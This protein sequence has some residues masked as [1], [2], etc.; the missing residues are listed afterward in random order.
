MKV[1]KNCDGFQL[2]D[3]QDRG[4]E[5]VRTQCAIFLGI[6]RI[7][8]F[9]REKMGFQCWLSFLA[10]HE[11]Q[12]KGIMLTHSRNIL[13][14]EGL[15]AAKVASERLCRESLAMLMDGA[16]DDSLEEALQSNPNMNAEDLLSTAALESS[17]MWTKI[18]ELRTGEERVRLLAEASAAAAAVP[19]APSPDPAPVPVEVDGQSGGPSL[20]DARVVEEEATEVQKTS[21]TKFF[22][23]LIIPESMAETLSGKDEAAELE[24]IGVQST[25]TFAEMPR[26][27]LQHFLQRHPLL[28][29]RTEDDRILYVYDCKAQNDKFSERY[30][31]RPFFLLPPLDESHLATCLAATGPQDKDMFVILD[32]R[33]LEAGS[34][35]KKA[36]NKSS[37]WKGAASF[38]FRLC[39]DNQEFGVGGYAST[40]TRSSIGALPEPIET[41]MVMHGKTVELECRD[42]RYLNLPGN[43][44]TRAL[45]GIHLR[46]SEEHNLRIPSSVMTMVQEGQSMQSDAAAVDKGAAAGPDTAS[47]SDED[48]LV[49]FPWTCEENVYLEFLNFWAHDRAVVVS[50]TGGCGQLELA[51]VILQRLVLLVMLQTLRGSTDFVGK[52]RILE[53]TPSTGSQDVAA[54]AP[55]AP[56]VAEPSGTKAD[57]AKSEDDGSD[58]ESDSA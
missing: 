4:R 1:A 28:S 36:I 15:P 53:E 19:A 18:K 14:E 11:S 30:P 7:L 9:L 43:S 3:L 20:E 42:R 26:T 23:D 21:W 8:H 55:P 54:V 2:S 57:D 10:F 13:P 49:W 56:P 31:T 37:K 51:C 17:F 12:P 34:K 47:G 39:Y 44:F 32:A 58:S 46:S 25:V 5:L 24:H 33:R 38:F 50:F 52:R 6:R 45:T 35:F 22:P 29:S 40:R 41:V 48:G 27:D 16:A